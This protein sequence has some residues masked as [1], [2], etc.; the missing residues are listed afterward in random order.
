MFLGYSSVSEITAWHI[1]NSIHFDHFY[2][3]SDYSSYSVPSSISIFDLDNSLQKGHA[4]IIADYLHNLDLSLIIDK[5]FF[6]GCD[7][8]I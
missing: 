4:H 2:D 3:V 6:Y 7:T 1:T 8:K 5:F